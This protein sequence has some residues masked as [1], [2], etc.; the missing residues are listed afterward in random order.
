MGEGSVAEVGVAMGAGG[1]GAVVSERNSGFARRV[2]VTTPGR[3]VGEEVVGGSKVVLMGVTLRAG[4]SG[5]AWGRT[6]S[7]R[8][9]SGRVAVLSCRAGPVG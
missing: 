1:D 6:V 2:G 3:I 5:L 8:P 9:S 4:L 7:R